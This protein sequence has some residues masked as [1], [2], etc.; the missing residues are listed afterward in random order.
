[1][2]HA[3]WQRLARAPDAYEPGDWL[4]AMLTRNAGGDYL[5]RYGSPRTAAAFRADV[6]TVD[7]ESLRPQIAEIVA[8]RADVLFNGKPV[9]YERTGGS[10]GGAKLV[11]Y[12]AAG[13]ADFRQAIL[14]WLSDLVRRYAIA[15]SAY[16]SISPATRPQEAI[17]G[18]PVGLPDGA[19]LG[20]EAAG[21][22]AEVTAVPV[23]LGALTDIERWRRETL[24]HLA[25]A[26]DLELI[27]VWS[28]TFLL[29]LLDDLP[30]PR[31]IW[32]RLKLVS[33]WAA[34]SSASHARELA[35]RLPQATLQAKGL[36]STEAVVTVPDVLDRPRLT[37]HG[38]FEFE[39]DGRLFLACELEAG[40]LYEVVATTASGLY[41]YRTGDLVR[42]TQATGDGTPVLEFEGRG[43]LVS[44]LVGEKLSEPFAARCLAAIG[45]FRMLLPASAGDGYVL[46]A[47]PGRPVNLQQVERSLCENPQYAYARRLGQLK[48]LRLCRV[49]GLF[50]RYA[51]VQVGR[52]VR[53]GDVKPVALR[54]ELSWATTLG[55]PP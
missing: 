35:E 42:C 4:G 34:A 20:S 8:G 9:A 12:S 2:R 24:R 22:L 27:S 19:Y 45:G 44:D 53:I 18:V 23:E 38:F 55:L 3:A 6:P 17:G 52:H 28:P 13:L 54:K 40:E 5:R 37:R 33:C 11:P 41:R 47:E 49:D 32:P 36:I 48:P 30:D 10:A 15:G 50:D 39:R 1:M 25:E 31:S 26:R 51:H 43:D 29:R 14:P 16:F 7:Y 46:A 21:V